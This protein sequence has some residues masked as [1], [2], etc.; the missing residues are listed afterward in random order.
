AISA[1]RPGTQC[2]ERR[3][4]CPERSSVDGFK[5]ERDVLDVGRV[6]DDQMRH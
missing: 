4:P 6:L 5:D 3:E 2:V 1:R